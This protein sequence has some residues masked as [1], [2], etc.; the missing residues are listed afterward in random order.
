MWDFGPLTVRE[1]KME[2]VMIRLQKQESRPLTY[3]DIAW[4]PCLLTST[5]SQGAC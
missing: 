4:I 1:I 2:E 3:L 5:A